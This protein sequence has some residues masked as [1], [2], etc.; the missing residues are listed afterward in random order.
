MKKLNFKIAVAFLFF[1][2]S[3]MAVNAQ[4]KNNK[5]N[6]NN[7]HNNN[8]AG[9]W[10][11][12]GTMQA[13]HNGDHDAMEIKGPHDSYRKLKIKV[14]NSPVNIQKMVVRYEDGRPK[15]IDLRSEIKEG[16]ESRVI[17]LQG[18]KRKLKAIDFWYDTKGFLNGK[19]EL[20]IFGMK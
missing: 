15:E 3:G 5:Y 7:N 8:N 1:V 12:L 19:A 9:S 6:N 17:D 13:T 11:I 18:G 10:R 20:T 4:N 2:M 14:R 16:G